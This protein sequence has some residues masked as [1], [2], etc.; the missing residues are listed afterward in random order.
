MRVNDEWGLDRAALERRLG[1]GAKVA[2]T[3]L[4]EEGMA[5][6][7]E[8]LGRYAEQLERSEQPEEAERVR[9]IASEARWHFLMSV[10]EREQ[11]DPSVS[12][13]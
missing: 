8:L 10:A 4:D 7:Q 11:T 9:T 13:E 6:V 2:L 5:D 3:E 12:T 1:T